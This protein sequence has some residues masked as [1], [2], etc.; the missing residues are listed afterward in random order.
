MSSPAEAH[1]IA[2]LQMRSGIDPRANLAVMQQAVRDAAEGGAEIL[3]TP[4]MS[5]LLDRDRARA[6]HAISREEDDVVLAGMRHAAREHGIW[7]TIGSLAIEKV[8]D[9]PGK[10]RWAN[11]AFVIDSDGAVD[12]RYDKL[13]LFDVE[14]GG[15]DDWRESS[16]YDAGEGV[17]VVD[18]PVGRLGLSICYDL[19]FP[20]LYDALGRAGCDVIAIP[21]AFTA[22]TGDAHWHVLQRAR[23]IEGSAYVVAAAQCG[24]HEDGRRTY[25]HSLVVD[26]WGDTVLDM[27]GDDIGIAFA[28]LHPKRIAEVRAKLPSL[29]NR[30]QLPNSGT[31]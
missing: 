17:E 3:F 18:T 20:A 25:G 1:R 16:A 31:A 13:H 11:R 2:V 23:A 8:V 9:D 30:R 6:S 14:L 7:V 10:R 15:D 28:D 24:R 22:P 4:E 19:R 21:A 12:A 26:P 27:G 29:A 5:G